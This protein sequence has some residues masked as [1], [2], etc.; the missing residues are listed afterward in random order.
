MYFYFL[1]NPPFYHQI[2]FT[3]PP[4]QPPNTKQSPITNKQTIHSRSKSQKLNSTVVFTDY[5]LPFMLYVLPF[6]WAV[7]ALMVAI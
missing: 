5:P 4:N 6:K 1:F 3:N 2:P 7:M